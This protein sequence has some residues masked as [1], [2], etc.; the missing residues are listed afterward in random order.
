MDQFRSLLGEHVPTVP[1]HNLVTH[2]KSL[3]WWGIHLCAQC[4]D[5]D[6]QR[7]QHFLTLSSSALRNICELL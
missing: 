3:Q 7:G 1:Q 5:G 6:N 4:I 2:P